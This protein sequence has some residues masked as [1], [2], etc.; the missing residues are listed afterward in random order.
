[1]NKG[2]RS[3]SGSKGKPSNDHYYTSKPTSELR[4]EEIEEILRNQE[5]KF[6]TGS[7]VFARRGID[8]GTKLLINKCEVEDDQRILDLGCGY[9]PVSVVLSRVFPGA[10]LVA[11]DINERAVML[12]RKNLERYNLGDVETHA[13]DGFAKINGEFDVILFN[14]PQNAGRDLCLKLIKEARDY[15]KVGGNIQIVLRHKK[16][17]KYISE[18]MEE[19]YGNMRVVARGSGFRV[20]LFEKVEEKTE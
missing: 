17:G 15:L 14:P 9:G 11:T 12:T 16:G 18:L 10:E 1:M 5:F 13:G 7:G 19:F 20:Y 3:R 8:N 6:T 2:K 4:T